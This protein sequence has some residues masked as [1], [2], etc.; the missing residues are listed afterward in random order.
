[1]S[2]F[3]QVKNSIL[4][5]GDRPMPPRPIEIQSI[6]NIGGIKYLAM[7]RD[8]GNDHRLCIKSFAS[9]MSFLL[10][11]TCVETPLCCYSQPEEMG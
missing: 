3:F 5:R 8:K 9:C 2:D 11:E 4:N 6:V 7:P 10:K 1:M